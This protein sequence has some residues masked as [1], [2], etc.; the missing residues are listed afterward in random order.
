MRC[1]NCP[2][3]T[4]ALCLL[5]QTVLV[6]AQPD[7]NNAPKGENPPNRQRRVRPDRKAERARI[8]E[9]R[10]K[11]A[12]QTRENKLVEAEAKRLEAVSGKSL[13]AEQKQQLKAAIDTRS[14]AL[15]A[16]QDTYLSEVAKLTGLTLD[17]VRLKMRDHEHTLLQ[18][19][20]RNER[21]KGVRDR[22]PNA[23]DKNTRDA[24]PANADGQAG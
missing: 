23:R 8:Q 16:A 13:D 11:K 2:I 14:N 1:L 10:L 15:R 4:V 7:L 20:R 22:D 6:L 9:A 21:D 5:S 3:I 18:R 19:A 17:E 12:R 24:A